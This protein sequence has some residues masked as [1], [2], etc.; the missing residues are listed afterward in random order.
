MGCDIHLHQEVKVNG[1]WLH[2]NEPRV[3]RNYLLFAIMA[4]VR[5]DTRDTDIKPLP[6][7]GLPSDASEITKLRFQDEEADAHSMSWI[8]HSEIQH[9]Y[10]EWDRLK[11][12]KDK[13]AQSDLSYGFFG[14]FAGNSWLE[15]V[16]F[17]EW[18]ED[19]RFV[20]WF[21]N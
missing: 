3:P 18:V 9:V 17:P 11:N 1:K 19:V 16:T 15:S 7:K 5:H 14:Y 4:G 21:D 8:G 2:F 12:E 6:Q 10:S 13:W 20:F